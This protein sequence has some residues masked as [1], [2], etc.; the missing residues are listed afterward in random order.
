MAEPETARRHDGDREEGFTLLEL[1]VVMLIIAILLAIAVP[2]FLGAR[3]RASDRAAQ[4]NVR[5]AHVTELI[6]YSDLLEFTEDPGLLGEAESALTYSNSLADL[7]AAPNVVYV[8]M[9]PDT[10]VPNDTVVLG[11]RSARGR[12]FWIRTIGGVDL[13]RFADNDC[14]LVPAA[15]EFRDRW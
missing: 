7:G 10:S 2:T 12:C 14:S 1:M 15:A 6:I 13:P 3:D 9:L 5:N 8:E 11:A 4:S